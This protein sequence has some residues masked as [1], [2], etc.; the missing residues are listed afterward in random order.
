[1]LWRYKSRPGRPP[2]PGELQTF[3]RQMALKNASWSEERIANEL[4][5]KPG[6]H[7]SP[8]TVRKYMPRRPPGIPRGDQRWS[9]FLR[10]PI[11][12]LRLRVL[13]TPYR[14]PQAN[15]ICERFVGTLRREFL[16]WVIPLSENH[17][18]RLLRIWLAHY[19][20]RRPHVSL[21]PGVADPP[22]GL[23][24]SLQS[25][26]HSLVDSFRVVSRPLVG[27]LHHEYT[28]MPHAT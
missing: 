8:R 28:L 26:S 3:I 7:A 15:A 24:V 16:D 1:L 10:N 17:L 25:T 14:T 5:L 6:L 23:P 2:T 22:P 13:K 18:R 21:G 19:N 20:D 4:L 12:N 27:G 11:R 9:T